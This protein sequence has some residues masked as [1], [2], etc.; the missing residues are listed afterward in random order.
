MFSTTKKLL[1]KFALASASL[2]LLCFTLTPATAFALSDQSLFQHARESYAAKNELAL[3][4]DLEDLNKQEYI[5]APY[6]DYWL[7]LLRLDKAENAEVESFLSR[8]GDLPFAERLRGEWL[9]KLGKQQDW[10]LFFEHYPHY[11]REDTAVLCYA[12]LGKNIAEGTGAEI[13]AQT[14]KLWMTTTDLPSTCNPLFDVMQK[15]GVLTTDDLWERFRMAL[16][17]GKLGL[18]KS[19]TTRIANFDDKQLKLID[20]ANQTPMLLLDENPQLVK[21]GRKKSVSHVSASFSSRDGIEIN[22][23]AID[24]LART[25]LP[26]AVK[27]LERLQPKFSTADRAFAWGR[28]GYHAARVHNAKALDY[29]ALAKNTTLDK[30]QLA[31]KVRAGLRAQNWDIVDATIAAMSPE[32]QQEGAWRYWKARALNEKGLQVEANKLWGPLSRERHYYGWLSAEEIDSSIGNIDQEYKVSELEVTAIASLPAI[33]RALELQRLDMRWESKA[34]WVWATRNFDDK[35]L[36]AAAEYAVRQ[37]WYDIAIATADNTKQLHDF[38]LRYPTPYRDLFRAAAL[39]EGV[40][41]AWIYGLVRQESRFMHYAKSGVGAAGLMQVMPATAKWAAKRM[42]LD[43]Y[44]QE[45]IHDINTNVGI[46]TYYMRYTLELLNG[47]SVLATAAYNAGPSRAKRWLASEPMESAIY[48]E[49]IPFAETRSYV[50][51]VMANAQMYA[52][53]LGKSALS[54]KSRL[55]YIAG[56]TQPE[57]VISD[58]ENE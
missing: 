38:S 43:S 36:L 17:Y 21:A 31:W 44:K 35:Q 26:E 1:S 16:Q 6:A 24:R 13:A 51:K 37:K 2:G 46:G 30:E 3:A 53:R 55:G 32:Q 41:E 49:T 48:I 45:L 14:K 52:P 12:L 56:V 33:K 20:I 28:I 34:E 27:V 19:I 9:K 15:S 11:K 58:N 50:Q 40:D 25:N 57:V 23:F 54:M 8:N 18:A 42:G 5:L 10:Q 47:Q 4:Q 7:M 39:N 22:L 29:Y